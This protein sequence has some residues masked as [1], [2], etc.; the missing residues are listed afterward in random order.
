MVSIIIPCYNTERWVA[1]AV[2]SCL[3]QTY[4]PIEIIVIDDGST[5][6]SLEVIRSFG[7]KIRWETGPNRGGCA[8]RNI[9]FARSRGEYIK[10]L[11]A[12]DLLGP[13]NVE[14]QVR[15]AIGHP[16]CVPYGPWKWL[17]VSG[18]TETLIDSL[19]QIE[20]A[21]DVLSQWL[22][23]RY[24]APHSLLWP[25]DVLVLVG[26][27]DETLTANQDGDVF[28]RALLAGLE[29]FYVPE[30]AVY[31]RTVVDG[32]KVSVS[33]Q[34]SLDSLRSRRSI[35][36]KLHAALK[37]RRELAKYAHAL[38]ESYCYLGRVYY[39]LESREVDDC[40]AQGLALTGGKTPGGIW[41]RAGVRLLGI[42][43][44]ERLAQ[45]WNALRCR[46]PHCCKLPHR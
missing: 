38:G 12:D 19:V 33:S 9:G 35:L 34:R 46:F 22:A 44:K 30:G 11:D 37:E 13:N 17:K 36:N 2:R 42:R 15:A 43:G 16:G 18:G 27:W 39:R 29:F 4:Q 25:R 3:D 40:F 20:A 31:Y 32:D 23:G 6:G 41:H 26:P 45:K 5:D 10:F 28:L 8:A 14:T 1:A 7:E 24:C 21:G